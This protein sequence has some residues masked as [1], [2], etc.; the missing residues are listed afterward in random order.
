MIITSG[1]DKK[2]FRRK[3]HPAFLVFLKIK[4]AAFGGLLIDI[5]CIN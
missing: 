5:L 1:Y 4:K 3:N 2:F